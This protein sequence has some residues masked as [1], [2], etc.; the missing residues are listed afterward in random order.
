MSS[1]KRNRLFRVRKT[2]HKML[3]ARGYLVSAKELERDAESFA[4]E[5]R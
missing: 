2:V 3:A 1:D 5:A 4:A